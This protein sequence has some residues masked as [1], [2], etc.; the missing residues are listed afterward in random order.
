MAYGDFKDLPGRMTSDKYLIKHL[1]LLKI[2]NMMDINVDFKLA[3][4]DFKFFD[5]N[6]LLTQKH[7]LIL[8]QIHRTN[9]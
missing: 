8:I 3:S 9:N 4:T 2:Q 6:L 5:T 7:K 1:V